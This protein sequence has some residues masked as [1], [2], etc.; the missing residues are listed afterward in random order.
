LSNILPPSGD[1]A[2]LCSK[3]KI[4]TTAY[5][6]YNALG[7]LIIIV[8][9]VVIVVTNQTLSTMVAWIRGDDE[10]TREWVE[11]GVM[12]LHRIAW[13][14]RGVGPWDGKEDGMPKTMEGGL[15]FSVRELESKEVYSS[16]N[17]T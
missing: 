11:T 4:R 10:K 16:R 1:S 2:A 17:F 12:Q 3:I 9:A 13:E 15:K 5:I 14:G 8:G 6:S 7:L